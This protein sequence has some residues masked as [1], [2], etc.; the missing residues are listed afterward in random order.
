LAGCELADH[1]GAP[2]LYTLPTVTP[3]NEYKRA[4][5][6]S[7]ALYRR[8]SEAITLRSHLDGL[9]AGGGRE[10]VVVLTGDMNDESDATTTLILNGPSASET[11]SVRFDQPDPG[12][13]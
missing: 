12:R 13:R 8:A 5:Y 9:L 3:R 7:Y 1:H 6:A 11:G 10:M 4:R 2:E